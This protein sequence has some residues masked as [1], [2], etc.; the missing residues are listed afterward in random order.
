[1]RLNAQARSAPKRWWI[2]YVAV[3]SHAAFAGAAT[4]ATLMHRATGFV[5]FVAK[6]GIVLP[7]P[8]TQVRKLGITAHGEKVEDMADTRAKVCSWNPALCSSVVVSRRMRTYSK[9]RFSDGGCTPP[10]DHYNVASFYVGR[11]STPYPCKTPNCIEE[12]DKTCY[13]ISSTTPTAHYTDYVEDEWYPVMVE[14]NHACGSSFLGLPEQF[15]EVFNDATKSVFDCAEACRTR[16]KACSYITFGKLSTYGSCWMH[17]RVPGTLTTFT[18]GTY[19]CYRVASPIGPETREDLGT[20]GPPIYERSQFAECQKACNE[21]RWATNFKFISGH[22]TEVAKFPHN[23]P[24]TLVTHVVPKK[25]VCRCVGPMQLHGNNALIRQSSATPPEMERLAPWFGAAPMMGIH[26]MQRTQGDTQGLSR[27]QHQRDAAT[28]GPSGCTNYFEDTYTSNR[29]VV[30][31]A[32]K[33]SDPWDCY[34]Q[35]KA[36]SWCTR[37]YLRSIVPKVTLWQPNVRCNT[38]SEKEIQDTGKGSLESCV[39]A[40]IEEYG[41]TACR[42]VSFGKNKKYGRCL[43]F[44]RLCSSP[45]HKNDDYD[46]FEIESGS[47]SGRFPATFTTSTSVFN[48]KHAD[49][50]ISNLERALF[51]PD[52]N[53][54]S[55][56]CILATEQC[57]DAPA[58]KRFGAY[59]QG[60]V[61]QVRYKYNRAGDLSGKLGNVQAAM[62]ANLQSP[63]NVR[64]ELQLN[65][66]MQ[67][68]RCG[69]NINP[70]LGGYLITDVTAFDLGK[71]ASARACVLK[72]IEFDQT[73]EW[74]IYSSVSGC[75]MQTK[76]PHARRLPPETNGFAIYSVAAGNFLFSLPDHPTQILNPA[77]QQTDEGTGVAV[78]RLARWGLNGYHTQLPTLSS[79]KSLDSGLRQPTYDQCMWEESLPDEDKVKANPGYHDAKKIVGKSPVRTWLSHGMAFV[80]AYSSRP[81]TSTNIGVGAIKFDGTYGTYA[82]KT[83]CMGAR[84]PLWTKTSNPADCAQACIDMAGRHCKYVVHADTGWLWGL[85]GYPTD[86]VYCTWAADCRESYGVQNALNIYSPRDYDGVLRNRIPSDYYEM[87]ACKTGMQDDWYGS[88]RAGSLTAAVQ[89][90][91]A[92]CAKACADHK[93]CVAFARKVGVL[94]GETGACYL[95]GENN[96]DP[97]WKKGEWTTYVVSCEAR[98]TPGMQDADY[99]YTQTANMQQGTMQGT[100]ETCAKA[101]QDHATC[102]AFSW[103]V[104]AAEDKRGYCYLTSGI[105]PDREAPSGK[106]VFYQ[107]ITTGTCADIDA[108]PVTTIEE[109]STA[110]VALALA[111]TTVETTAG[112]PRP[113]G[114]YWYMNSEL[115]MA[116]NSANKGKGAETSEPTLTRHPIC[117][118]KWT[119]YIVECPTSWSVIKKKKCM[120]TSSVKLAGVGHTLDDCK[121]ECIKRVGCTSIMR[122]DS[123]ALDNEGKCY[124][125]GIDG[126]VCVPVGEGSGSQVFEIYTLDRSARQKQPPSTASTSIAPTPAPT[127]RPPPPNTSLG[128]LTPRPTPTPTP[129]PTPPPPPATHTKLYTGKKCTGEEENLNRQTSPADCADACTAAALAASQECHYFSFAHEAAPKYVYPSPNEF[130]CFWEKSC[131]TFT[132]GPFDVYEFKTPTTL[133]P[134]S[135]PPTPPPATYTKI[136]TGQECTDVEINLGNQA[137]MDACAAACAARAKLDSEE[138]RYFAF[139]ENSKQPNGKFC[140]WEKSCD[141]TAADA[142][143]NVYA[144]QLATPPPT[145]NPPPPPPATYTILHTGKECTGAVEINLGN[146]ASMDACAAACAARAKLDSE[147][148][149]YFAFAEN[150]EQPNGKFCFWEKS[151]DNTAAAA[152]FNVYAVQRPPTPRVPPP[153]PTN[154]PSPPSPPVPTNAPGG[155]AGDGP[156]VATASPTVTTRPSAYTRVAT[157][158]KIYE[159]KDCTGGNKHTFGQTTSVA[160]CA[161][162]CFGERDDDWEYFIFGTGSGSNNGSCVCKDSCSGVFNQTS[163]VYKFRCN[164]SLPNCTVADAAGAAAG[165]S[166]SSGMAAGAVAGIVLGL[167]VATVAGFYVY[168]EQRTKLQSE[169]TSNEPFTTQTLL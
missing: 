146:Q 87:T 54:M 111:D 59:Q 119:T 52:N 49:W 169:I 23:Q 66:V 43:Y 57:D 1:M 152:D 55:H 139:A 39:A 34:L 149:R 168:R 81:S 151:C 30:K 115:F 16:S 69:L 17:T 61:V 136:Y 138:C 80:T 92:A 141:N 93:T 62:R 142:D 101:C 121:S 102:R 125:N 95:K 163:D 144:L 51:C 108:M 65:P 166:Q 56:S 13:H 78:G 46:I 75:F 60:G 153:S 3:T 22:T 10:Q 91:V 50:D 100:V 79:G 27:T 12:R 82:D 110:A 123:D 14:A 148:C 137:S 106:W 145:S 68:A 133:P 103:K 135:N 155:G 156:T 129:R 127:P 44:T 140:F 162:K 33:M 77:F 9:A 35:C 11:G 117:V 18:P 73:C 40:C 2:V 158:D 41:R 37:F 29:K 42:H 157:H 15:I 105:T 58:T 167:L 19:D 45:F 134:T 21:T 132:S 31:M 109:C 154:S 86:R 118:G 150:S 94:T 88:S 113:E 28:Q 38:G 20:Y 4:Q 63:C 8:P 72:C 90:N 32:G 83:L 107:I 85:A 104:G 147:E 96:P 120:I 112:T 122:A 126:H 67:N 128:V 70:N 98:C 47:P 159:G 48:W 25:T 99:G 116:V 26:S 71:V 36:N 64:S 160:T 131:D 84:I 130:E 97:T 76:C 24:S 6:D 7:D 143:F 89:G 164:Q 165:A 5:P 124:L 53:C 114:C 74:V 161:Y